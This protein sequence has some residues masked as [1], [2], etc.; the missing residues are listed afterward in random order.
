MNLQPP[1]KDQ[2]YERAA[3]AGMPVEVFVYATAPGPS[4]V[5]LETALKTC[6]SCPVRRECEADEQETR[7]SGRA[8]WDYQVR[9]GRK[10][11]ENT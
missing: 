10:L 11:W 9:A 5:R 7:R 3:C 6:A 4:S 2:W 8:P 1:D